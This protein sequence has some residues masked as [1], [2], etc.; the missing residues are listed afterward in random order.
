MCV[1]VGGGVVC[2]TFATKE[3]EWGYKKIKERD[4]GYRYEEVRDPREN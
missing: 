4:K 3:I 2:A 1:C